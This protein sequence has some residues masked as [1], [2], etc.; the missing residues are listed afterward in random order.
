MAVNVQSRVGTTSNLST[1]GT[2]DILLLSYPDG[3]P[4]GKLGFSFTD[5][6]RKVT[7]LEKV[8]Q[9]FLKVLMTTQGSDPVY[10]NRGTQFS[11]LTI[12]ANLLTSDTLLYQE[13]IAAVSAATAQVK[14]I[15]NTVSSDPGSQLSTVD[16]LGLDVGDDSVVMY[17]RVL[18]VNGVN[19]SIAVP[20]P[21]LDL[22]TNA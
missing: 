12:H 8:V 4:E 18:T 19:A 20:F 13:L 9:T 10:P 15:L 5:T 11:N 14:A 7:G 6:P 2:Y 1:N 17:L 16:V 3:F 21:S 22:Q